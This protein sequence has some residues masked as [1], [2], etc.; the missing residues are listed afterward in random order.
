MLANIT[1]RERWG[2]PTRVEAAFKIA[3]RQRVIQ[4]NSI[5]MSEAAPTLTSYPKEDWP[6]SITRCHRVLRITSMRHLA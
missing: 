1:P 5:V 6:T 4:P 2:R 3:P